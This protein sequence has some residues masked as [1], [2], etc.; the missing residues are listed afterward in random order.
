MTI[1]RS[2]IELSNFKVLK[3]L[4]RNWSTGNDLDNFLISCLL[5]KRIRKVMSLLSV[6]KETQRGQGFPL[7]H[8]MSLS[9]LIKEISCKKDQR[10]R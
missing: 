8:N 3:E 9:N 10:S 1:T 5:P 4:P 2:L 7:K 6:M